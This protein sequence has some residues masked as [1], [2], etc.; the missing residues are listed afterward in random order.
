MISKEDADDVYQINQ[1]I[2]IQPQLYKFSIPDSTS[3]LNTSPVLKT[4]NLRA[5]HKI[6]NKL[7]KEAKSKY[8]SFMVG[9]TKINEL[10]RSILQKAMN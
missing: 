10:D 9:N 1:G 3:Q 8:A 7:R 6:D 4:R 5:Y 2:S